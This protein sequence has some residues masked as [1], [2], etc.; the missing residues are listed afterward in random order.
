MNPSE[1][2]VFSSGVSGFL[3]SKKRKDFSY[4]RL[5]QMDH[6]SVE[7]SKVHFQKDR[8]S[9]C[10]KFCFGLLALMLLF[11]T[12][13]T[14]VFLMNLKHF[15]VDVRLE[16]GNVR[17]YKFDQ[18]LTINGNEAA[19][20]NMSIVVSM[21]VINRT[22]NDCWFAIVLSSPKESKT[23]IDHKEFTFLTH[24][25]N[26]E[27]ID[28]QDGAQN[29]FKVFGNRDTNHELSF[30]VHNVLNQLL[31]IINVNLY[32]FVLSKVSSS[33]RR[34]AV[35]KHGFFPGRVHL[36]R[37]MMTNR[38]IVT[39]TTRANPDDFESFSTSGKEKSTAWRLTYDETTVVNKITGM[40]KRGDMSI[41]GYLPVGSD[42]ASEHGHTHGLAVSFRSIV[43]LVDESEAKVKNWESVL[44]EEKDIN[45]PLTPPNAKDM[46]LLYFA[47]PKSNSN[48]RKNPADNIK[49]LIKLSENAHGR[50][51]KLPPIIQIVHHS[52]A[53]S[54][55]VDES[56]ADDNDNDDDYMN[57]NEESDDDDNDDDDSENDNDDDN[58]VPYWPQPNY[59]PYGIGYEV[60]RKRSVD[61][62][63]PYKTKQTTTKSRPEMK[64]PELDT[65]WDE[66]SSSAPVPV[67]EPPRVIHT[68]ILGF[69]FRAEIEY[70][71]QANDE[72]DN[73]NDDDS[74]NDN[75]EDWSVATGY[76][77]TFG[78][79]RIAPFSRV[80]TLS[81]LRSKLP[82]KGQ[83]KSSRWTV[84]AGDF[85]S[86]YFMFR[87]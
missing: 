36:K 68:S 83:R 17:V 2:K 63:R 33:S 5:N 53:K 31:P 56:D 60:K 61:V 52:I 9:F 1:A 75:D 40:I 66:L 54:V 35:E 8:S 67:R 64:M 85:V 77:I 58:N 48:Y 87:V 13:A 18:E 86:R 78:Q 55:N 20:R 21:H 23:N 41:S 80:H 14:A 72:N 10:A 3:S 69:D 59:A 84:N 49:E 26:A 45:H 76:R 39:V 73:D 28:Y 43:K 70:Q 46:S 11:G 6:D 65:I 25:T 62:R 16:K 51:T 15:T 12:V 47:P 81:K 82:R 42:F 38:D 27:L 7:F 74:D 37:T 34:I 71:V 29:H 32:E 50:S 4:S 44:K 30:Y 57:Y 19:T 79:Y 24:V 22:E